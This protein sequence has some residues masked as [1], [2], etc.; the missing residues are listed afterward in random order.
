MD[1]RFGICRVLSP[2]T[3]WWRNPDE[4]MLGQVIKITW[5]NKWALIELS[6]S[7]VAYAV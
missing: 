2:V 3:F 7:L 5:L 6:V 1:S 4:D